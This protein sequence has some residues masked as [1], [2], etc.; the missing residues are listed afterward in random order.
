MKLVRNF[1]YAVGAVILL[2]M[3]S[4]NPAT[5]TFADLVRLVHSDAARN[6]VLILTLILWGVDLA[7]SGFAESVI[8][9]IS[10]PR[11]G[12]APATPETP[13]PESTSPKA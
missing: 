4:A 12:T 5:A 11:R 2:Y 1:F 10:V 3:Y 9:S 7:T 13:S 8:V 6:L